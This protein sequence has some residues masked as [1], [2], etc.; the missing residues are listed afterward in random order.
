MNT[1]A[2]WTG[3]YE[4]GGSWNEMWFNHMIMDQNGQISGNGDDTVGGFS[5]Q[6]TCNGGGGVY[7]NK[8]YHGAHAVIYQGQMDNSGWIRGRWEIQGNCDGDF[9]LHVDAPQWSGHYE[10]FGQSNPMNFGLAINGSEVFGNG[11]DAI[12]AFSLYGKYNQ[13][14]GAMEFTKHY[15]G[16][17]S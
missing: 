14:D 8:Q 1:Q 16:Q 13:D 3:R 17:H 2:K 10:Q 12:G 5:L 15:Y 9:E 4:Q 11:Y 6:G 7:I